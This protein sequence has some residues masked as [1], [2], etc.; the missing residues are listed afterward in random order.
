MEKESGVSSVLSEVLMI[1]LVLILVPVVTISLMNQL[2]EDRVPTVNIKMSP[3]IDDKVTFYHK[4]GDWIKKSD[5][6][7]FCNGEQKSF[8]YDKPVFDLGEKITVSGVIQNDRIDFV[9][10]NSIIFSGEPLP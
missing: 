1:A 6:K 2:P 8:N 4:G 5:I 7:I 3:I 10:K 9:A